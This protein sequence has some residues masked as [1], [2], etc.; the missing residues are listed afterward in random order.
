VQDFVV[1]CAE[2]VSVK[3]GVVDTDQ[4]RKVMQA[5]SELVKLSKWKRQAHGHVLRHLQ[6]VASRRQMI[7]PPKKDEAQS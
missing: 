6:G 3:G 4:L 1:S 2:G 5:R 7:L